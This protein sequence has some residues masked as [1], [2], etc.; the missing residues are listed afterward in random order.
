MT[1]AD[2]S[3]HHNR[4]Y[5]HIYFTKEGVI[6]FTQTD[7]NGRE[8]KERETKE[9]SRTD[10]NTLNIENA[11]IVEN[12]SIDKSVSKGIPP[13]SSTINNASQMS[14]ESGTTFSYHNQ[15]ITTTSTLPFESKNIKEERR[16]EQSF[17][18]KKSKL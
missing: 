15:T 8:T 12:T 14:P 17:K 1:F 18:D 16:I 5:I 2:M 3:R 10:A 4:I 13:S 7:T 11:S 6:M 9:K